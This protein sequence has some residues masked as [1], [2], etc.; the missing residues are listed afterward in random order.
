MLTKD[1]LNNKADDIWKSAIKLR[2]KFK[3][4]EYQ[5]V[6]LPVITLRRIECVLEEMRQKTKAEL[7]PAYKEFQVKDTD[8]VEEKAAKQK[9]LEAEMKS[10]ELDEYPFWNKTTWTIQKI[11]DDNA[12]R[13]EKNFRDYING[14][15]EVETSSGKK[16]INPIEEIFEKFEFS[17]TIGSMEKN[18][19]LHPILKQYANEPLGPKDL[20][21]LEMGYI[22]E[23][24]L[25]KFSEQSG[26]CLLYTSPSPRD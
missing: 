6:V 21:N 24:L 26:D 16:K 14:F 20:T 8:S 18:D 15:S 25:R 22:Y 11:I 12:S 5:D 17:A 13:I 10:V 1:K 4:Y 23:E 7:L 9:A 2:G 3:A 19:A